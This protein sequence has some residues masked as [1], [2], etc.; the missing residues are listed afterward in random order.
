[1][2]IGKIIDIIGRNIGRIKTIGLLVIFV[3]FIFSISRSGC[4][5]NKMEQMVE[6][7]T[8]LNVRNDILQEDIKKRD[9]LMVAKDLRI[10]ALRDSISVYQKK[11][12]NLQADYAVLESDKRDLA[13]KLLKVPVDTSYRFL[14]EVAYPYPGE[15]KYPF[16]E[17]QVRGIHLTYLQNKSFEDLNSNLLAQVKEMDIQLSVKDTIVTEQV[18]KMSLM[19]ESHIDLEKIINNKDSVITTKDKQIKKVKSKKTFWQIT[20]GVILVVL[21]AFAAGS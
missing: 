4:D 5:R 3:L 12:N 13:N 11:V 2:T 20:V 6:R 9:S 14:T 21:A 7:I 10:Q 8:G 1:M 18:K 19:K 16:N 17:P 15:P